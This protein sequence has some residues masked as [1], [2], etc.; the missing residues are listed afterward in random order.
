MRIKR[1]G[2]TA[3]PNYALC[4]M[5]YELINMNCCIKALLFCHFSYNLLWFTAFL[6]KKGIYFMTLY[7]FFLTLPPKRQ[8]LNTQYHNLKSIS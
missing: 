4:I 8:S 2:I 5:N 3:Q 6:C 7:F 1:I